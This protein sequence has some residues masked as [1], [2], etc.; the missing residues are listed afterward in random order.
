MNL[1]KMFNEGF[2]DAKKNS[3]LIFTGLACVGV[4]TTSIVS[5]FAGKKLQKKDEKVKKIIEEK[6]E[7]GIVVTRKESL[8]LHVREKWPAYVA[9]TLAVGFTLFCTIRSYKE[10]AKTIATLS[11]AVAVANKTLEETK[12]ASKKLLGEKEDELQRERMKQQLEKN[13]ADPKDESKLEETRAR[14][15]AE[16][17]YDLYNCWWEPITN[18]RVYATA[19]SITKAFEECSAQVKYEGT[20]F[21]SFYDFLYVLNRYT[22]VPI[23]SFKPE[24]TQE[25]GWD[26]DRVG[27]YG[28]ITYDLTKGVQAP[29]GS[30][31]GKIGYKAYYQVTGNSVDTINIDT[32]DW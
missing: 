17:D 8:V 29:N 22:L 11:T 25:F 23:K 9:P 20:S 30:F 7:Q 13:P 12:A 31:I 32:M 28:G 10:A 1:M 16:G 18:Q 14:Q 21:V 19:A 2:K 26:Y 6:E 5:I 27:R 24:L 3:P 15:I 4:I